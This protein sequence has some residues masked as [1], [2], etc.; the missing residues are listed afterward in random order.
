[1]QRLTNFKNSPFRN[2]RR[3]ISLR[4][5]LETEKKKSFFRHGHWRFSR[6]AK[7][8]VALVIVAVVLV[9]SLAFLSTQSGGRDNSSQSGANSTAA[10]SPNANN[11]GGNESALS[12]LAKLISQIAA[13]AAGPLS[14]PNSRAPGLIGSAPVVNSTVWR[15]VAANAWAYFQPGIGVDPNTGLPYAGGATGFH[16]FTDWDLG[17]YIQAVIDAQ[18]IGL[19]GTDGPWGTSTRLE[20]VMKIDPLTITVTHSSFMT[21]QQEMS[22]LFRPRRWLML[23][24]LDDCLLPLT[25]L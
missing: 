15:E 23:L 2:D 17:V 11:Q 5:S 1:M 3:R 16:Y 22:L 13:S 25:I 14:P 12:N 21:Q 18:K 10:P 4:A 9:S 24:I 8:L 20:K 6:K 7:C 19:I